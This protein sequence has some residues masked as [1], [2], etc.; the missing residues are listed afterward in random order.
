[1]AH[2]TKIQFWLDNTTGALTDYSADIN[3]ASL[4]RA[5]AVLEDT[6][7]NV[8]H[9]SVLPGTHSWSVSLNGYYNDTSVSG[10]GAALHGGVNATSISKTF[11]MKV[12]ADYYN[13]EVYISDFEVSGGM[14][15]QVVTWSAT[16]EGDDAANKTSV[17]L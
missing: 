6:G 15:R 9:R 2:Q 10:I 12:G 11:Q 7:L 8:N 14:G 3:Q 13:G 4:R 5:Q 17:A 1:M 16:L